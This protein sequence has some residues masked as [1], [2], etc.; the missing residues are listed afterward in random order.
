MKQ[1]P[2]RTALITGASSGIGAAFA[3][4]LA[5]QNYR[6]IL[7]ARR[8]ARLQELADEL[9]QQCHISAEVLAADLS[10]AEGIH[11]VEERIATAGA[12]DLL[13]NNAGF[14]TYGHF[15][16]VGA[17]R[18]EDM[19]NVHVTASIRLCRAALPTMLKRGRGSIINVAS[20]A[21]FFPLPGNATYAAS[22]AYL[23][24][25]SEALQR[26]VA[27]SGVKIQA[28]CPG[29]TVT[30]FH[31]TPE[32]KGFDRSEV[33][34]VLWMRSEDVVSVSLRS[35]RRNHVICIPG[36]KYQALVRLGQ[37]RAATSLLSVLRR[38][39]RS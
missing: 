36:W 27:G 8:E 4:R 13:I 18:H 14:G 31:G 39:Q 12:L 25:F 1:P 20:V 35:L 33:P 15:T 9:Q 16:D 38:R 24:T 30:E 28:L 37:N 11:R 6:L 17:D 19:I 2:L 29:F 32:Y 22:K 23:V 34:K 10:T 7:V 21:A 5:R 26:E 3:R